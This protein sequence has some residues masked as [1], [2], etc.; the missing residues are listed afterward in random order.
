MGAAIAKLVFKN[1]KEAV[2]S[3]HTSLFDIA[4]VNIDG[5]KAQ[6]GTYCVD[7]KAILVVNVASH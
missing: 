4:A 6:L 3:N 5:Q 1:G 2:S 7:K